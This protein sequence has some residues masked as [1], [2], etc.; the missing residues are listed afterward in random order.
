[1]EPSKGCLQCNRRLRGR[2]D[3]K[4]CGDKCRSKYNYRVGISSSS[5]VRITNK[6]LKKNRLILVR[7]YEETGT[8]T[9]REIL[10]S[11]GFDF[12]HYT[13]RGAIPG[14]LNCIFCYEMGYVICN[15]HDIFLCAEHSVTDSFKGT[16]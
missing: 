14:Y 6:I 1:M 5:P 7:L 15:D 11:K 9:S 2:T 16:N 8:K 4:F 13:R 10:L 3:K 12:S